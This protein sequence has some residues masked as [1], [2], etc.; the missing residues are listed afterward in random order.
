M[1]SAGPSA[2]GPGGASCFHSVC[3]Q[4]VCRASGRVCAQGKRVTT[5]LIT[6]NVVY[7]TE[8]LEIYTHCLKLF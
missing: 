3:P 8:Y 4:Q 2:R 1:V 7:Y 5:I 6:Y